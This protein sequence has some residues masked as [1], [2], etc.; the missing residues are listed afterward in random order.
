MSSTNAQGAIV[1]SGDVEIGSVV[2]SHK[3]I[4]IEAGANTNEQRFIGVNQTGDSTRLE[5]LL[6]ALNAIKVPTADVIEI[7]KGLERN[8][9]LHGKLIIE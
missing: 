8:G 6:A 4:V 9:K 2:V 3:S 5:A 1:I 7:I